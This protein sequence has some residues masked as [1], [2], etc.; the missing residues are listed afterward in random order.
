MFDRYDRIWDKTIFDFEW[1]E[2]LDLGL[3][4][5]WVVFDAIIV[6]IYFSLIRFFVNRRA[7]TNKLKIINNTDIST[8]ETDKIGMTF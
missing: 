2:Y 8:S 1:L 3:R 4:T 7:E 6:S 5:V